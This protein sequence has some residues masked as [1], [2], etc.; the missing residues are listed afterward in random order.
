MV[1]ASEE[2]MVSTATTYEQRTSR[3]RQEQ[4]RHTAGF[5]TGLA[6]ICA[7]VSVIALLLAI[8]DRSLAAELVFG[9]ALA[10]AFWLY[11]IA[12]VI[13]IRANTEK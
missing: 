4:I 5:F 10:S 13:H 6:V 9:G 3:S 8:A 2:K 1:E 7:V 11:L 12:Q